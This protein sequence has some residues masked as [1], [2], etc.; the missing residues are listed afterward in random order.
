MASDWLFGL[1]VSM[2]FCFS[3]FLIHSLSLLRSSATSS[4]LDPLFFFS[5]LLQLWNVHEDFACTIASIVWCW[6]LNWNLFIWAL[7]STS[8]HIWRWKSHIAVQCSRIECI[9]ECIFKW[10]DWNFIWRQQIIWFSNCLCYCRSSAR[11][12]SLLP[13]APSH[14]LG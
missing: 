10:T 3:T 7:H 11:Y 4:L 5:S 1:I 9:F 2:D 6:K 12:I 14:R 8:F 13:I